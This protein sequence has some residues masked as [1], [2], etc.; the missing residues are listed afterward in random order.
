[1]NL[2]SMTCSYQ[3]LV[4]RFCLIKKKQI[5]RS[6]KHPER[7]NQ[8]RARDDNWEGSRRFAEPPGRKRHASP[9]LLAA[10]KLRQA[11]SSE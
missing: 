4:C 10:G 5:P 9:G 8:L 3:P 6:Q 2:L 7:K 1:M 11:S